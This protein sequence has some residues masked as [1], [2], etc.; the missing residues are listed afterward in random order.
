MIQQD[1][2]R[3]EGR[4]QEPEEGPSDLNRVSVCPIVPTGKGIKDADLD[5]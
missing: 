1:G 4:S 5:L 3:E 2:R